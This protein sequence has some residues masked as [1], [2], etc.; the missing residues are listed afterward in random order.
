M[1]IFP[2]IDIINGECV[3]L[4]KG[5]AENKTIYDNSPVE[6]AKIYQDKGFETIKRKARIE[7]IAFNDDQN[8]LFD[9]F[10]SIYKGEKLGTIDYN[11]KKSWLKI[12]IDVLSG[13]SLKEAVKVQF[14]SSKFLHLPEEKTFMEWL[15]KI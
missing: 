13:I 11:G 7:V 2:A 3:R 8:I 5:L 4:T 15:K 6:M 14:D 1:K 10:H 9:V 12:Y